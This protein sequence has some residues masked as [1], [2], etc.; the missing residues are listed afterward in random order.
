MCQGSAPVHCTLS[1]WWILLSELTFLCYCM[2]L[3]YSL[4]K[5]VNLKN[6]NVKILGGSHLRCYL[7]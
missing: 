5:I 7:N 3:F 2:E 4:D 6:A 1:L